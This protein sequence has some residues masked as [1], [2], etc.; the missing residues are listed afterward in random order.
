MNKVNM[1]KPTLNIKA[2]REIMDKLDTVLPLTVIELRSVINALNEDTSNWIN[3]EMCVKSYLSAWQLCGCDK[4]IHERSTC[5]EHIFEATKGLF[6]HNAKCNNC[7]KTY[8][9]VMAERNTAVKCEHNDIIKNELTG[10]TKCADCKELDVE[11]TAK[12]LDSKDSEVEE[13][14][15]EYENEIKIEQLAG[16]VVKE[17]QA[18]GIVMGLRM[19]PNSYSKQPACCETLVRLDRSA[20]KTFIHELCAN[21]NIS[22]Q[23]VRGNHCDLVDHLTDAICSKFASVPNVEVSVPSAEEIE[24]VLIEYKGYCQADQADAVREMLL[25][26]NSNKPAQ[27]R[28]ISVEVLD[29]IINQSN[30]Y[31]KAADDGTLNNETLE[32]AKA[33]KREI[34]Q[35]ER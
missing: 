17:A 7:D 19:V 28:E 13:L 35:G 1:Q 11:S 12:Q 2:A 14:I 30:L 15:K 20:L 24:N 5:G 3:E 22:F 21:E 32:L 4:C 27:K 6:A 33:I 18:R 8:G 23:L 34:E 16:N 10:E 25:S 29:D 9:Q 26:K 31:Y